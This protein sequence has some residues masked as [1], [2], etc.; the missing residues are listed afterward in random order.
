MSGNF[1]TELDDKVTHLVTLSVLSAEYEKAIHMKIPI[2]T[3]EWVKAIWEANKTDYVEPDDKRFDKYKVPMFYNLV[4]TATN[5]QRC[6]KEEISCLI[7]NYGGVYMSDLDLDRVNVVL[8]PENSPINE[9]LQYAREANIICLTLNWL[10]ESIKVGHALPVRYYIFQTVKQCYSSRRSNVRKTRSCST[11]S[12]ITYDEQRG[13]YIDETAFKTSTMSNVSTVTTVLD[14]PAFNEAEAAGPFLYGC[15]IYLAGFTSDQ[16]DKLNRILN[17]GSAMRFDYICDIITHVIVGDEDS[18]ASELKLLKSK[19][20]CPYILKLEW[21]EESIR[22]KRTAPIKFFLYEQENST[23]QKNLQLL[24]ERMP[25]EGEES[26]NLDQQEL[27]NAIVSTTDEMMQ[28]HVELYIPVLSQT[29]ESLEYLMLYGTDNSNTINDRLFEGLTF[30]VSDFCNKYNDVVGNIV[31]MNGRVVPGTFIEIPDYGIVPKCGM[32]LKCTVKEIVTDLFIEDCV[33]QDRIVEVMYYHR[34]VSVTKHVLVGCVLTISRYVGIERS[35]LVTLAI[36]LGAIYQDVFAREM[37]IDRDMYKN[38]HL[39]CPI[40]K[41]KKYD[42]AVRWEI[43]VVTA[44]WLKVCAAQSTRVDETPF[45]IVK[46]SGAET[47]ME[48]DISLPQTNTNQIVLSTEPVA[49]SSRSH[50]IIVSEEYF[51]NL[52]IQNNNFN[53]MLLLNNELSLPMNTT[54]K[55]LETLC[56]QVFEPIPSLETERSRLE[57]ISYSSNLIKEEPPLRRPFTRAVSKHKKIWQEENEKLPENH[58]ADET[59]PAAAKDGFN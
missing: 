9:E 28:E 14:R 53:N 17:V 34:P 45:L 32:T 47:P 31:A 11:T 29:P 43:P 40:P 15:I 54:S 21:L 23:I 46:S 2:V 5:I 50:N 7:T 26:F 12:F 3:K 36:E 39:I 1:T 51:S 25:E 56:S 19:G 4:V 27:Q 48:L 55:P 22:L 59:L 10:Y 37:I 41:G 20:F 52:Q 44:E 57:G 35:Y 30:V 58:N 6:E 13:N 8:T 42:A 16:R 24:Q 18:A 49:S 38:T 33:N